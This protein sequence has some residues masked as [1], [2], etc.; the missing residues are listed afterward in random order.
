MLGVWDGIVGRGSDGGRPESG[1]HCVRDQTGQGTVP[2]VLA[3]DPLALCAHLRVLTHMGGQQDKSSRE[4]L[5]T[6]LEGKNKGEN[7]FIWR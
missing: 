3:C 7:F 6:K 4:T 5:K 2:Q 1:Q